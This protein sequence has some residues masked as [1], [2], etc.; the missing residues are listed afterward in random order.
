MK[1]NLVVPGRWTGKL[2]SSSLFLTQQGQ[3][4]HWCKLVPLCLTLPELC[5]ISTICELETVDQFTQEENDGRKLQWLLRRR[6]RKWTLKV[7]QD[8]K[9]NCLRDSGQGDGEVYNEEFLCFELYEETRTLG[10]RS[11]I[12]SLL[13]FTSIF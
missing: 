5:L 1:N 12:L 4:F 7:T 9:K 2:T 13:S 8:E 10:L 11:M 6:E 3:I